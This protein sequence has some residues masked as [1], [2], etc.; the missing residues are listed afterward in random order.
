MAVQLEKTLGSN[1]KRVVLSVPHGLENYNL[2][3]NFEV[4]EG[5]LHNIPDADS[6]RA[7][8]S[9]KSLVK[10]LTEEDVLLVLISGTWFLGLIKFLQFLCYSISRRRVCFTGISN[11]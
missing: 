4:F 10:T 3:S 5:A 9:I 6:V 2:P 7:T 11:R 1:L 8:Q